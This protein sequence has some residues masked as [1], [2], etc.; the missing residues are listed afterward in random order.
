MAK[1]PI[2]NSKKG[3][4]KCLLYDSL[5]CSQC[6]GEIRKAETC[7]ECVFYSEPKRKYNEVPAFSVHEMEDDMELTGYGNSIEGALCAFDFENGHILKD[8]QAIRILELL[9]DIYYYQDQQVEPENQIIGN[10]LDYVLN[11]IKEDLQDVSNEIIVKLLGVIRFVA[12]R[13]TKIGR[14]YMNII[15]QYVGQRIGTGV[16][17]L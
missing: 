1:C 13:R 10:G 12:K 3:K 4:R 2:C 15:H 6:C 16:R 8:S 14:E 17:F 9:I 11:V 5:I 7:S